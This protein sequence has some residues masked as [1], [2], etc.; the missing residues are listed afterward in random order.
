MLFSE[1]L[2]AYIFLRVTSVHISLI[3]VA[4]LKNA[5]SLMANIDALELGPELIVDIRHY[6]DIDIWRLSLY[7]WTLKVVLRI[8]INIFIVQNWVC[9]VH[10]NDNDNDNENSFIVMNYIVQ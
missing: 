8:F 10:D 3:V 5:F 7:R 6:L 4:E 9:V 1:F 2:M